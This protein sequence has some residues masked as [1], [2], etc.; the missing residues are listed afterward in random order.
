[1]GPH[2]DRSGGGVLGVAIFQSYALKGVTWLGRRAIEP[3][4][5][6]HA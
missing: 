3:S 6:S 5:L 4:L 1:M 2:R